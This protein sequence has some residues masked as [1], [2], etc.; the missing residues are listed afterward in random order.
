VALA[1]PHAQPD[2]V[3]LQFEEPLLRTGRLHLIQDD[4]Q[5]DAVID[6]IISIRPNAR[7]LRS[8]AGYVPLAALFDLDMAAG[9][10]E[11]EN[12]EPEHKVPIV[13]GRTYQ[14]LKRS[15]SRNQVWTAWR[16]MKS[17]SVF[18]LM[19]TSMGSRVITIMKRSEKSRT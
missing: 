2:C 3:L 1:R 12:V 6:S 5:L 17:T 4:A 18:D 9:M 11:N 19:I 16:R 15:R 8:Q 13:R 10:K 14:R 7:I